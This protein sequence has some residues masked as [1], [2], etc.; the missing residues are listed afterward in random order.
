MRILQVEP[1]YY[2]QYPPLGLMKLASLHRS[3]GN[4]VSLVRGINPDIEKYPDIIEITSLFT[5]SW[6]PVHEAIEYYH[7]TF[8]EAKIKVGGIYAS[9]LPENIKKSFP[10]VEIQHGI[11]QNAEKYMPA[12]DILD[13]VEKWKDWKKSI[14]FT[15]RGCIRKCPFCV[16]PKLE[17]NLKAVVDDI[18]KFIHPNHK[19]VIFWDNNFLASPNWKNVITQ[20][21]ELGL[22]ADFNQ[23]LDARLMDEEK[24]GHIADLK[25]SEVRMAYDFLGEKPAVEKAIENLE[26]AGVKRRK[27]LFYSLYN[28]YL[29]ETQIGDTPEEFFTIIK[30]IANMGCVSY[31]MRYEPLNSLL[32]NSFISP[33]WTEGELK[34]IGNARRVIGF[35]GAFPPYEGLVDKFVTAE[36][37]QQAFEL[38]P[39]KNR[40][41]NTQNLSKNVIK[42]STPVDN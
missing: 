8:P 15:S 18:R 5:Y 26:N 35:G 36:N 13:N 40:K 24:A 6:K 34:M 19:Q 38:R 16:V 28:F 27:I 11:N 42:N 33:N 12:Y 10:F 7:K 25:M 21:L 1:Q 30:D 20:I 29:P 41:N 4:N 23:G 14:L 32:K 31:P 17:G 3:Y 22:K 39:P 9:I 37:F 2:T